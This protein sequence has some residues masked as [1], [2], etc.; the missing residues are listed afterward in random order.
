MPP[1]PLHSIG[2]DEVM[3]SGHPPPAVGDFKWADAVT[4]H[5][6]R[7]CTVTFADNEKD[8]AGISFPGCIFFIPFT[9][10]SLRTGSDPFLVTPCLGTFFFFF[11]CLY[12]IFHDLIA[13]YVTV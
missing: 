4:V 7:V 11:K 2:T 5:A 6:R 3:V 9:L 8:T 12:N 10:S 13:D 1:P